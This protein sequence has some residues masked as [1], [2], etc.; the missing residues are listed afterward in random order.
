MSEARAGMVSA[1]MRMPAI[2]HDAP[3]QRYGERQQQHGHQRT[4]HRYSP[5]VPYCRVQ[6]P[7]H[8]NVTCNRGFRPIAPAWPGGWGGILHWNAARAGA[9]L[10]TRRGCA[11][12][13]GSPMNPAT[14]IM[15]SGALTFGVP[16]A[17][18]VRDLVTLRRNP[19]G[20]GWSPEPPEPAR[21]APSGGGMPTDRAL[22]ACLIEA[23]MGDPARAR[24]RVLE[25]V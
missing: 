7:H 3:R 1:A 6:R 8:R 21:P 4:N 24:R 11:I 15:L 23:A 9:K 10:K 25:H 2:Y 22:P 16:L 12:F 14:Q 19:P 13:G 17:L 18:A 20:G 5:S